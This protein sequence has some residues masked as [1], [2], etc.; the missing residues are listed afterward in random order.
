MVKQ[1]LEAFINILF[2]RIC[3]FCSRKL[4]TKGFLC[5]HCLEKIAFLTPPLCKRC[6][7]PL[8]PPLEQLCNSCKN[9]PYPYERL[10]SITYYREPLVTLLHLFKYN[11]YDFLKDFFS[12]LI[13]AHLKKW[14]FNCASFDCIV[15]VP[16]HP[17]RV[18]EREYNQTGLL[19]ESLAEKLNLSF[20]KDILQCIQY[21]KS[22]TK[23]PLS[24]RLTNTEGIFSTQKDLRRM[25][26]LL[27]DDVVTTGATISECSKVLKT[28]GAEHITV[29]TL[30][31]AG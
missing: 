10:I 12:S 13:A 17:L 29:L 22:Q 31:K 19:A 15:S 21:H 30:T 7:I 9:K 8:R 16:S 2:P 6:A 5:Q 25:R 23:V 3:F 11:Q 27:L 1:W 4:H 14:G 24:K 20:K 26:I 18:R 28:H